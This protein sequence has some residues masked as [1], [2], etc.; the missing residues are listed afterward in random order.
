[1]RIIEKLTSEIDFTER[2]CIVSYIN[3]YN[4]LLLRKKQEFIHKIDWWTFDGVL[5]KL[6]CQLLTG[7]TYKRMAPDFGSYFKELF[8]HLEN[9]NESLY[10]IGAKQEEILHFTTVVKENYQK[11]KVVGLRNG[12]IE[13]HEVSSL[14]ADIVNKNPDKILIGMGTPKQEQLAIRI[15]ELKIGSLIFTCGAFIAQTAGK[16]VQYYP[17]HINKYNLRWIYRVYDNPKLIKRYLIYYPLSLC[18]FIFD[19]YKYKLGSG[20]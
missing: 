6:I 8:E 15:R 11:I 1:M 20:R 19:F 3:V 12:Y 10:I 13:E 18:L 5:L 4:Y 14:L 16:G 9:N 17:Y 2:G 7:K